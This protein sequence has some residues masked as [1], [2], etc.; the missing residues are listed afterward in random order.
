MSSEDSWKA[1][2]LQEQEYREISEQAWESERHLLGRLLVRTSLASQGQSQTLDLLLTQLRDGL[3][4]SSSDLGGLRKLQEAIDL[5]L[6]ELDD[7]QAAQRGKLAERVEQLIGVAQANPMFAEEKDRLKALEM[8]WHQPVTQSSQWAPWFTELAELMVR[9][10]ASEGNGVTERS[11]LLGRL[12]RSGRDE[13]NDGKPG[14]AAATERA[15]TRPGACAEDLEQRIQIARRIS[16]LLGQMLSQLTLDVSAHAR[17]EILRNHLAESNDWQ[18]LRESLNEVADLLILAIKRGQQEFEAFLKRLDERLLALQDHFVDQTDIL[19][20]AEC[21]ARAFD[22]GLRSELRAL[23]EEVDASND[24]SELKRSVSQHLESISDAVFR[25]REEEC[26]RER[27]L[28]EQLQAMKEKVIALEAHSEQIKVRLKEERNRALTDVLT[29][30]PNREAW[31]QR[32][33]FEM[34]RWERYG[35]PV[36]IGV[37]DIDHFKRINDSYGHKAGDRVI[38]LVAKTLEGRLRATDFI[39]RYGGEEFVLMMPETTTDTA[40][41]VLDD[42]RGQVAELP[43]HFRGEPVTIT[44]SAG[45]TDL[46]TG[47]DQDSVFDRADKVLYDAKS[48]GR[49]RVCAD[50]VD[51]GA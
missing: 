51:A 41:A 28:S 33:S 26:Q 44:F 34:A 3:R 16:E 1:K 25:Y 10:L 5:Q 45:L 17:A 19:A 46:R 38:Q 7:E 27:R 37:L 50:V 24:V 32:M 30:L 6:T 49:N 11:G 14:P 4:Q 20:G 2:Y 18:E 43:F 36:T 22:E 23:G 12:F 39:A 35:H 42:L 40:K 29:Q 9:A 31:Q 13:S 47:D 15:E 48:G 21:A 8:R